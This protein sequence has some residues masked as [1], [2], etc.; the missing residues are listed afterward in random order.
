MTTSIAICDLTE[1]QVTSCAHCKA[2]GQTIRW[3]T[4]AYDGVCVHPACQVPIIAGQRI[5][6]TATGEYEHAGCAKR[7]H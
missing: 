3:F 6:Q 7:P 2:Q 4:A 5:H 1:L